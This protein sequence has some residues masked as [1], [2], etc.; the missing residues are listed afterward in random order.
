MASSE[1]ERNVTREAKQ[2]LVGA[3]ALPFISSVALG[4]S[5]IFSE[6]P[7][8]LCIKWREHRLYA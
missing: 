8:S 3:L 1:K 7:V 2:I 4:K 5:L 6:S